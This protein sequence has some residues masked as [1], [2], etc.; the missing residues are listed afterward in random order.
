ME[1]PALDTSA[2]LFHDLLVI[3]SGR[4]MSR[5]MMA[6]S[7]CSRALLA[8]GGQTNGKQVATEPIFINLSANM[9]GLSR[10]AR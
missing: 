10:H 8:Q 5:S 1:G 6:F 4:D 3:F 9:Q 7:S 2:P